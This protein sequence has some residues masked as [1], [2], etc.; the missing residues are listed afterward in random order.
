VAQ[1]TEKDVGVF[2]RSS[3]LNFDWAYFAT[4]KFGLLFLWLLLIAVAYFGWRYYQNECIDK[5]SNEKIS[6]K[7]AEEMA[8]KIKEDAEMH[9]KGRK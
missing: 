4:F 3:P 8:K 2:G 5:K 6:Q 7:V 1:S 9:R